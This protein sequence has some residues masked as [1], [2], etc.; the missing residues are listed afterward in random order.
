MALLSLSLPKWLLLWRRAGN[1]LASYRRFRDHQQ[2][3]R[4][5]GSVS[6]GLLRFP[7][8]KLSLLDLL[9]SQGT[10][11]FFLPARGS[12]KEALF[13]RIFKAGVMP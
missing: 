4:L 12:E 1:V 10:S 9:R 7:F 5:I 13:A 8:Y 6:I 3:T 2:I 11:R